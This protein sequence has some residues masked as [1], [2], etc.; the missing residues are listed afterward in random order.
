[1]VV[2]G[3]IVSRAVGRGDD[4]PVA[5][6]VGEPADR[7]GPLKAALAAR[8]GQ[9]QGAEAERVLALTDAPGHEGIPPDHEPA[10][11]LAGAA[12]AA[13]GVEGGHLA[14]SVGA[15]PAQRDSLVPRRLPSGALARGS[16]PREF[17]AGPWAAARPR[18]R[19]RRAAAAAR[20][21]PCGP[22]RRS[23]R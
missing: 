19:S 15:F 20:S 22:G 17:L 5:V 18:R 12:G 11:G 14:L 7:H 6:T 10:L 21:R 8:G 9:D 3:G 2:P 16:A 1:V 4:Q 23:P 13:A